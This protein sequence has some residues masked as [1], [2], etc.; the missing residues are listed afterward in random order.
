MAVNDLDKTFDKRLRQAYDDAK[1]AG[2]WKETYAATNDR[3]YFAE[4]A[5]SWFDCNAPKGTSTTASTRAR[6][7][8]PMTRLAKLCA[9]VFG[10]GPWRYQRPDSAE[11][12]KDPAHLA[13]FDRTAA[14]AFACRRTCRR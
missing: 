11:R 13:G 6:S 9:E 4:G 8:R 2:L 1:A 3:E 12:L 5:Q 10:D 14:P 7:S